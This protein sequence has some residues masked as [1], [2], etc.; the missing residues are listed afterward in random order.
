MVTLALGKMKTL[1]FCFPNILPS[2]TFQGK[3]TALTQQCQLSLPHNVKRP[4]ALKRMSLSK[5]L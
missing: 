3:V 1:F 4:Q 2:A 5:Y